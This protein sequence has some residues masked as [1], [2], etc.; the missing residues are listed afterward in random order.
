M[1]LVVNDAHRV[2]LLIDRLCSFSLTQDWTV[3]HSD[4]LVF[5]HWGIHF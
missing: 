1:K 5:Q 4:A 2:L 3:D